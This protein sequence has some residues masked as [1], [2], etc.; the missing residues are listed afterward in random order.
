MR[1]DIVVH[2]G[3]LT[4]TRTYTHTERCIWRC[5]WMQ[6]L[7]CATLRDLVG[8][9]SASVRMV[10]TVNG[11]PTT[12]WRGAAREKEKQRVKES[13]GSKGKNGR[14]RERSTFNDRD[15]AHSHGNVKLYYG[16]RDGRAS[17]GEVSISSRKRKTPAARSDYAAERVTRRSRCSACESARATLCVHRAHISI[18]K[19]K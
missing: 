5:A 8:D 16:I 2:L 9:Q 6:Q 12:P 1:E 13:K 19:A 3:L 14:E 18:R 10:F 4:H 11:S 15:Q 17:R 7:G